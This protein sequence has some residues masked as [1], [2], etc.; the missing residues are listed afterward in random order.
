MRLIP[1]PDALCALQCGGRVVLMLHEDTDLPPEVTIVV[2][3]VWRLPDGR[4]LA[5]V[6]YLDAAV[7]RRLARPG[8]PASAQDKR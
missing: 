3:G 2:H 8:E 6:S 1:R 4:P 7:A 5:H